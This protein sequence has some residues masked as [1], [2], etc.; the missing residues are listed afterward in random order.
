MLIIKLLFK[1]SHL[2]DKKIRGL[3]QQRKELFIFCRGCCVGEGGVYEVLL[4]KTALEYT[5]NK[6]SIKVASAQNT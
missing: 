1:Y 2:D 3:A 6:L 4:Y 5:F